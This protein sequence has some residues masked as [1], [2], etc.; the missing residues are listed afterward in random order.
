MR[1]VLLS[2][3]VLASIMACSSEKPAAVEAPAAPVAAAAAQEA[4]PQEAQKA[5]RERVDA[6][7]IARRGKPLS[8]ETA[9]TVAEAAAKAKDLDGKSVKVA[10]TVES[11]CQ[12]MGCWFVIKGATPEQNIRVMSKGHDVF[13]PR[14]SAGRDVVAEGEFKVKT[15]SKEMAQHFEDERELKEGETRKVF[16]ADVQELSLALTAAELQPKKS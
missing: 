2:S 9:L 12:P 8:A 13:M 15:V 3:V 14:T 10:G 1:K 7:G 4:N 16:T 6:D 11:V 5:E